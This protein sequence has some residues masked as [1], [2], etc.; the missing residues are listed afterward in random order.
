MTKNRNSIWARVSCHKN[1]LLE[2][3]TENYYDTMWIVINHL[4][5]A[6]KSGKND[7]ANWTFSLMCKKWEGCYRYEKKV[8]GK[9]IAL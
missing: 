7:V 4:A 3:V 6:E 1:D 8:K 5:I 9:I 2:F